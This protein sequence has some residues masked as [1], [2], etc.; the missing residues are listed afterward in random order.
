M[1][2]AAVGTSRDRR[3]MRRAIFDAARFGSQGQNVTVD[4]SR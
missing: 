2:L 1:A 3:K 4:L